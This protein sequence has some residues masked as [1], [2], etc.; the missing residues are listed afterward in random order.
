MNDGIY[1]VQFKDKLPETYD[2]ATLPMDYRGKVGLLK[3]VDDGQMVAG[4]GCR[5]SRNTFVLV[6]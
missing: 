6:F 4:N 1:T 2:D 5:I 3:L